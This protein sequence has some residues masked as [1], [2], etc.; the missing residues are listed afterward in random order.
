[1]ASK[2]L[3]TIIFQKTLQDGSV[4]T[5]EWYY[6]NKKIV[7]FRSRLNN[8]NGGFAV[9]LLAKEAIINGTGG[10]SAAVLSWDE[11]LALFG[12]TTTSKWPLSPG[13]VFQ[14]N[15]G[16]H[17][18]ETLTR[19]TTYGKT[20]DLGGGIFI[21]QDTGKITGAGALKGIRIFFPVAFS[22]SQ[23]NAWGASDQAQIDI[24]FRPL[25]QSL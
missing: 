8:K 7:P 4:L 3:V 19:K 21:N 24:R 17:Y 18:A 5:I 13:V 22:N 2:E 9:D 25:L 10:V 23:Y 15:R 1:M 12:P 14:T 16:T 20:V 6:E 11:M